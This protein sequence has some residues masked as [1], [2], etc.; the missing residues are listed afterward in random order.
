M[1]KIHHYYRRVR[2]GLMEAAIITVAVCAF[3]LPSFE[4]F[5]HTGDNYFTVSINGTQVGRLGSVERLDRML[6]MAR[7][8][9]AQDADGSDLVFMDL[10]IETVGSER[11]FGSIDDEK[12]VIENMTEMMKGSIRSTLH[13]SYTVKV[14]ET[15]V[16]LGSYEEVHELLEQALSPYDA[17]KEYQV[18]LALDSQ[19]EVNVLE[20]V[21]TSKEELHF[22]SQR[23]S[24]LNSKKCSKK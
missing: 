16:N 10:D 14:N 11:I 9:V 13:R 20:A 1:K 8:Q 7:K 3:L 4:T 24:K 12:T 6:A 21:V 23:E 15:S 18:E 19:R 2:L 17:N 5:R 22:R